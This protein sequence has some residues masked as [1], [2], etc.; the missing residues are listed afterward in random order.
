MQKPKAVIFDL[1]NTLGEA[2]HSP[3]HSILT[4]FEKVL[5]LVPTAIMTAASLGRI[6]NDVLVNL[7]PSFDPKSLALFTANAGQCY[8]W[9]ED[10]WTAQYGFSFSDEERDVIR[11]ALEQSAAETGVLDDAPSY[12]DRFVDYEGYIAFTALGVGAPTEE[13]KAWDPDG[14]KRMQLREVLMHKLP[15][16]DVY[17]GGATSVD[18]T[19][20]GI[21][22]SYGVQW[23]ARHLGLEPSEMLYIGDA[24]YEGGNDAVVIP[25]GIQTRPTSGPAETE[26]IIDELLVTLTGTK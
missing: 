9:L 11:K 17:I 12:G 24:L 15:Q 8:L 23:Y 20:K 14:K 16:F 25:T 10:T 3:K 1:D 22:K 18:V 26:T 6:K 4:R 5:P 21:N 2:F 7:S 19:L 13:R